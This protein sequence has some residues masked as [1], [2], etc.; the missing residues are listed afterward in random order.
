SKVDPVE[1]GR[2][3]LAAAL[4]YRR[5]QR[6]SVTACCPPDHG[7]MPERIRGWHCRPS[8]PCGSPGKAPFDKWKECQ[9]APPGEQKIRGWWRDV[10]TANV[11]IALGGPASGLVGIDVDGAEGEG[12]L[13]RL[14][15][16]DLP[17][18]LEFT[19]GN[20]RRLLYAVPRDAPF[21]TAHGGRDEKR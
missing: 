10:T 8:Q 4:G 11:G 21:T 1:A 16:G 18:T 19:S 12:E 7:E 2:E 15:G 13:Q 3:C 20:G 17:P 6:W 9:D 5:L 14:S